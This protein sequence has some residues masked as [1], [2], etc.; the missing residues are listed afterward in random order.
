MHPGAVRFDNTYAALPERFYAR[1]RPIPVTRP[2]TIRVHREL[3]EALG[4]DAAW[5]ASDEGAEFIV[6]NR[7]LP[8]SDPI[9]MAY[10][11]HQFGN[12]N[13]HLG[14]GRAILLGEV[15]TRAGERFDLHLKGSGRTPYSRSGDGRAP[16]GPVLREYIV[17]E[18]MYALGVPTTRSLAVA[19]SGDLVQRERS[20]PG[21]VL[22]RVARSHIRVGT[23]EYYAAR[24]D[25]EALE[26]LTQHVIARHYPDAKESG[27]PVLALLRAVVRR[28]AELV[29]RWQLLG[30]IHGVMNTDNM[31][32]S[33][34]TIDYGP[35]AFMDAYHADTSYSSIDM[36]GRYRYRNQPGIA[37]FNLVCFAEAL[38]PLIGTDDPSRIALAQAEVDA[39]PQQFARAYD[40]GLARK[41]GLVSFDEADRALAQDLLSIMQAERADFTL[42]FRR[43]TDLAEAA[44]SGAIADDGPIAGDLPAA[45][46]PWV[47]R[48]RER[49]SREPMAPGERRD[50]MRAANPALI[51]RNH[52]VEAALRDA[53][54][55]RDYTRFHALTE[56]LCA[57]FVYRPELAE[58]AR[59]PEPSEEV[60][61]TFCGT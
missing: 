47:A 59:P 58:Y 19:E 44:P 55:H 17:S 12:F 46:E 24:N 36:A 49:L 34:E 29:A 41:L 27:E 23:F 30:F 15:L 1:V 53:V 16:L 3:A 57:P 6:G 2:R 11:G 60:R 37:H 32:V 33:G 39:F 4:F 10:A 20:L 25:R 38:L 42:T 14:D 45:L 35:C 51:P 52:L 28:Q 22:L 54:E 21:G 26:L 43:L 18:A 8:G 9:A 40:A 13:P 50:Q 5:L 48:W 31:L 56:V 7:L 61:R